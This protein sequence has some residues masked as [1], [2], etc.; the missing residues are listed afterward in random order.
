MISGSA[1]FGTVAL[2]IAFLLMSQ[3]GYNLIL[4]LLMI[5]G[6]V[7]FRMVVLW[8]ALKLHMLL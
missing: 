4:D 3:I 1:Y 5:S 7:N 8:I 2:L 6:S